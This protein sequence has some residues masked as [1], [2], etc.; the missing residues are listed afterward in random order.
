MIFNK[1]FTKA[2]LINQLSKFKKCVENCKNS[3]WNISN[4]LVSVAHFGQ[5]FIYNEKI[6]WIQSEEEMHERAQLNSK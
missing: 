3:Y 6:N 4:P 1:A 2:D 5:F